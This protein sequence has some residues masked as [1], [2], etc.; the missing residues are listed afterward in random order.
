MAV[1]Q[2]TESSRVKLSVL[3]KLG[4]A[5]GDF[6]N[7]F[8]WALIS[9]YLMYFWTDVVLIPATVCGTFMLITKLWD[10]VND[11]LIGTLADRTRTRWGRYRPWILFACV[12]MLLLNILCFTVFPSESVTIRAIYSLACYFVLVFVY[13]CVNIP[14]SA[15]P[16]AL[17]L[18][19]DTRSSL[20][21]YRMTGAFIAT[22]ILSQL[23]LRVV[24]WFGS[25]DQSVGFFWAAVIFSCIALPLYLICFATTKEI[26]DVPVEKIRMREMFGVIRGNYPV[27]ILTIT[28]IFWGFYEAA[29]GSVR[30]YYFK[31][32][33]GDESLFMV[34]AGLMFLGRVLGTFSLSYLVLR[35]ANKATLPLIGFVVSGILLVI[36]NYLP[37]GTPG[38]LATYHAMTF[39][40]GVGGGLGLASL[41]GMVP[42][43]TEYTQYHYKKHAAGF[44]SSFINF[45][46]KLG[47]ALCTAIIGWVLGAFGYIANQAQNPEVLSAINI[48]MNLVCGLA[49]VAGG[50]L[51]Y[52]YKLDK[53]SH[54]GMIQDLG[55]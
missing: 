8:S 37:V 53:R 10:A 49:L 12:P 28:F 47:M 13:T 2:N 36:M 44:V 20:A 32:Y 52:F 40:T 22:L 45:A 17:T 31:Y 46:F 16:A 24:Q 50:V 18:D 1:I 3:Q 51:L 15:L 27:A 48:C 25:E 14:Y 39:L 11:P 5:S 19:G 41:F 34:N 29:C 54:V 30:M 4:Y 26:V 7:N 43:T 55:R 9:A 21:A 23:V 6:A 35:V 33:V 42:D 38:G